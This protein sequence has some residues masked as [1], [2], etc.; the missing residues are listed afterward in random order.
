M[1]ELD[2]P[3]EKLKKRLKEVQEENEKVK[4]E[5]LVKDRR[6]F[7]EQRNIEERIQEDE[8]IRK[9]LKEEEQQMQ[10]NF[11]NKIGIDIAQSKKLIGFIKRYV[12]IGIVTGVPGIA[13]AYL[14]DKWQENKT[15][16]DLY[17]KNIKSV[18]NPNNRELAKEYELLKKKFNKVYDIE[19]VEQLLK[20][21]DDIEKLKNNNKE[22]EKLNGEIK[23]YRALYEEKLNYYIENQIMTED[24]E[25]KEITVQET[26]EE[27][28][29][30]MIK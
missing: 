13:V 14:W 3:V 10:V 2:K 4:D 24:K 26:E 6:Y 19:K 23:K 27:E 11:S 29:P 28:E 20:K 17:D 15:V 7:E 8:K 22:L 18:T 9:K 30:E 5:K 25:N 12:I 1:E 16:K 21:S